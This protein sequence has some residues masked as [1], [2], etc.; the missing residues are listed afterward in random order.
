MAN[1][2]KTGFDPRRVTVPG[3]KPGAGRKKGVPNRAT[4]KRQ[5]EIA[6]SGATPLE[7]MINVMRYH[8]DRFKAEIA[9]GD[10]ADHELAGEEAKRAA[11]EASKAAPYVHPRLA[12]VAHTGQNGGPIQTVD[13]TKMSDDD[14]DRLEAIIG[15][16]A[17][18]GGDQGG[19]GEAEGGS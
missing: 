17:V 19:E 18:A 1:P 9:K 7:V 14:L 8:H 16:I 15:P 10:D 5:E 11:E 13:L 3:R 4:L 2:F 12:S 6:A